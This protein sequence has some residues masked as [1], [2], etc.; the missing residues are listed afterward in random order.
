MSDL[1]G[2][3]YPKPKHDKAP[4]FVIGKLSINLEQFTEWLKGYL[5]DNPNEQWLNIDMKVSKENKGYAVID[6]WKPEK[7]SPPEPVRDFAGDEIP[8]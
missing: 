3:F 6:D 2:G 8:F 5:A 7:S 4:D 1:I